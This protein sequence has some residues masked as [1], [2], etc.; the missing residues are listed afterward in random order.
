MNATP[1]KIDHRRRHLLSAA[2][3]A[4]AARLGT[5]VS[6]RAQA[7]KPT[8]TKPP[9]NV[10]FGPLKHIDAGLLNV[11]YAEGGPADGPPVI[12][13]HG[14]P[15]DIH[16]FVDRL[17]QLV[18]QLHL[19]AVVEHEDEIG[20]AAFARFQLRHGG[21][22]DV[23]QLE[24]ALLRHLVEDAVHRSVRRADQAEQHDLRHEEVLAQGWHDPGR[25]VE[26]QRG[27]FGEKV[28][29]E[30]AHDSRQ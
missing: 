27:V 17:Q 28:W 5:P 14:W 9:T 6:V 4:A 26:D 13:L 30:C 15:Y 18:G 25:L 3:F 1:Q 21:R 11:A 29:I 20:G 24:A 2:A 19:A 10:S 12:L 23:A 16:S 8:L 22:V 7:A